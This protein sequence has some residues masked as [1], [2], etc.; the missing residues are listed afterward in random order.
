MGEIPHGYGLACEK[1]R[2]GIRLDWSENTA[3]VAAF[4]KALDLRRSEPGV[5]RIRAKG[6]IRSDKHGRA[7]L[8]LSAISAVS[9]QPMTEAEERQY[10]GTLISSLRT[11]QARRAGSFDLPG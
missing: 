1:W 2:A 5:L 7:T 11:P 9:F 10:W 8:Q 6:R 4:E 3:G